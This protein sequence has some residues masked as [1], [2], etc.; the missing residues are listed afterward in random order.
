MKY[1]LLIILSILTY[2]VF[3]QK[4]PYIQWQEAA[5]QDIRLLP[6]YGNQ[7]KT[8]EQQKADEILVKDYLAQAGTH[9]KASELLIKLGFNYLYK[10]DPKTAMFRFNQA[11]IL[12]PNNEN[13]FWGFGGVYSTL[14]DFDNAL[15]QYED[16][17]KI[18]PKSSNIITDKATIFMT[19][20]MKS[21]KRENI[22]AAIKL[23]N[24]SHN[25]DPKNQNTLFKMS[26]CYYLIDDCTNAKKHYL[27][28]KKLGGKPITTEYTNAL[29]EKC[30]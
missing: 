6:K 21:G 14:G 22:N 9:R 17:L 8:E 19:M 3:A 10:N 1:A 18:N 24:Q 16:G 30:R 23:F 2:P 25:I 5:K 7:P 11:W 12:D 13:V 20:Y 26:V 27:E 4:T 15:V 28:C 29:N